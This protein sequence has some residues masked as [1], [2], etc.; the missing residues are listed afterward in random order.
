VKLVATDGHSEK[1]DGGS[2]VETNKST[3][4]DD[5]SSD[6]YL[7]SLLPN[8]I[9][10][11]KLQVRMQQICA[12]C[13]QRQEQ[14]KNQEADN[15]VPEQD[16]VQQAMSSE[17]EGNKQNSH[18]NRNDATTSNSVAGVKAL[19]QRRKQCVWHKGHWLHIKTLFRILFNDNLPGQSHDRLLQVQTFNAPTVPKHL[20]SLQQSAFMVGDCA[21]T[22]V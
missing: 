15:Q 14:S 9:T 5:T 4:E 1:E 6:E 17:A 18:E 12:D 11:N 8:D 22:P 16:W 20:R 7:Q 21:L 2:A 13:E 3:L 10:A 19:L